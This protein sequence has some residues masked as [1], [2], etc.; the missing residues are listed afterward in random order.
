MKNIEKNIKALA[1]TKPGNNIKKNV[2]GIAGIV[3][4]IINPNDAN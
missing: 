4:K 2:V 3:Q 1:F